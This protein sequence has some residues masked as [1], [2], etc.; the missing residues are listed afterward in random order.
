MR[1]VQLVLD[2]GKTAA[3]LSAWSD[4]GVCLA[5]FVHD[6]R[7]VRGGA[8]RALDVAGIEAW[9]IDS[10]RAAGAAGDVRAIVPVA[11]GA[12]AAILRDGRLAAPVMDYEHAIPAD[13]ARSYARDRDPETRSGSP[14]MP[15][16]LNLGRQL[17]LLEHLHPGILTDGATI[18]PWA[19]FWT[20]RLCGAAVCEVSSLG[21]HTDLWHPAAAA[22]SALARR[23]GWAARL[24]R[25]ARAGDV[26]GRLSE[27]WQALTGLGP[28]VAIHA[29]LHDSNAAL[30]AARGRA[31]FAAGEA[32]MLSTGTWFVTMRSPAVAVDPATV[33]YDRGCLVNVDIASRPVPTALFMGGREFEE[34]VS[35]HDL[36]ADD[37]RTAHDVAAA[38]RTCVTS[39]IMA[40]AGADAWRNRPDDRATTLAASLLHLALRAD[41][42]CDSIGAGRML[43]VD[44][45]F[46]NIP[47]FVAALAALRPD[48]EVAVADAENDVALGAL[49]AAN[50]GYP[51]NQTLRTVA[52]LAVDLHAYRRRWRRRAG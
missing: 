28:Q 9:L 8:Y 24:A 48:M 32:T 49:R 31:R 10:L 36:T 35:P 21:V 38:A 11:H 18:V 46:A 29:G 25:F 42:A 33:A 23:R 52:P 14:A 45:R 12:A 30:H 2:V 15:L 22:P 26:V 3:K 7:P 44:G 6:N 20:W 43:V 40:P 39:D 41:I 4:D 13:I 51:I 50:P 37:P 16:G 1:S 17:D 27:E 19:Q 47:L 5:R 34:L